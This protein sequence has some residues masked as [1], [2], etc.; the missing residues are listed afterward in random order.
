MNT[1]I[2]GPKMYCNKC[3]GKMNSIGK[4]SACGHDNSVEIYTP[5]KKD[6]PL[7]E[8]SIRLAL[9]MCILII[10]HIGMILFQLNNLFNGYVIRGYEIFVYLQIFVST[11]L[12]VICVFI[13]RLKKWAFKVYIILITVVLIINMITFPEAYF[14][15]IAVTVISLILNALFL[16]FIFKKDWKKFR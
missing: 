15:Y 5:P 6:N 1:A 2:G 10:T 16:Y 8:I 12:I 7:A 9:F 14:T 11:C 4:C 13:L 3:G